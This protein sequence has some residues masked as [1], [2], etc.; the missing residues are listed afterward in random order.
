MNARVALAS[1]VVWALGCGVL[2]PDTR[3]PADR[4]RE[5]EPKCGGESVAGTAASLANRAIDSVEPYYVTLSSSSGHENRMLGGRLHVRPLPGATAESLARTLQCHQAAVVG[6]SAT[7]AEDDPYVLP[8]SWLQIDVASE[9]NGFIV[10]T[11]PVDFR[12]G[13]EALERARRFARRR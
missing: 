3:T 6:G 2:L 13:A 12:N 10:S 11:Y 5:L 4:A 8:G 7:A 1:L 9:G